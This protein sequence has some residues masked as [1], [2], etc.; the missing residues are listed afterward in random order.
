MI[1]DGDSLSEGE[2]LVVGD[3]L[4]EGRLSDKNGCEI[5]GR[6][7]V[8]V[9]DEPDFIED[10][11]FEQMCF[12][13]DQERNDF[14]LGVEFGDGS[15]DLSNHIGFSVHGHDTELEGDLFVHASH[16]IEPAVEIDGTV[17]LGVDGPEG[18]SHDGGFAASD[19]TGEQADASVCEEH[20]H[21]PQHFGELLMPEELLGTDVLCERDVREIECRLDHDGS[22]CSMFP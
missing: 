17:G 20:G 22:P 9:V 11:G 6:V 5:V 15:D 1:R 7:V 21:S 19:L 3:G 13:D 10:I 4:F 16:F 8:A 14:L 12:I 2:E 18:G